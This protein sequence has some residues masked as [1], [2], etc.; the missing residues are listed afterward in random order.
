MFIF[1]PHLSHFLKIYYFYFGQL[2]NA[3]SEIKE[4]NMCSGYTESLAFSQILLVKIFVRI[5]KSIVNAI[6]FQQNI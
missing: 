1:V 5:V 6:G 3:L 2:F 4:E